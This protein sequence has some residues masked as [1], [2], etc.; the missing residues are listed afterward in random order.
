MTF[1][2]SWSHMRN[3]FIWCFPTG[4]SLFFSGCFQGFLSLVFKS[5]IMMCIDMDSWDLSCLE[6]LE[7]LCWCF[8][9]NLASFQSL[10]LQMFIHSSFSSAFLDSNDMNVGYFVISPQVPEALVTFSQ[11]LFYYSYWVNSVVLSSCSLIHHLYSTVS[12][13][14]KS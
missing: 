13:S 4:T 1:P 11:S 14:S 6:F 9:S 7:S 2:F 12:P 8:S 3:L 5:L 10:F